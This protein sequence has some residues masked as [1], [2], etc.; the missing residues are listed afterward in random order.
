[1]STL[2][3]NYREYEYTHA[4]PTWDHELVLPTIRLFLSEL[5]PGAK[6]V[7]MGCGNGCLIS[8]FSA[9]GWRLYGIEASIS[10][11]ERA[12]KAYPNVQFMQSDATSPITEGLEAESFDAVISVEVI[13]HVY[14]PR[15]MLTK[16]RSLLKPGGTLVLTT[17]Y[18]GYLKSLGIAIAGKADNHYNPLWDGGHIKFWSHRT[19]AA[20]L[21]ECGFGDLR[22]A[23]K[24]RVPLLWKST[25][26]KATKR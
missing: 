3:T 24:G 4:G 22:F 21:R 10:G 20:A 14:D 25:I 23:P 19:L 8:T 6:V 12:R 11:I 5:P 9:T 17:P 15:R 26:I 18:H 13:E 7:D 2:A 16:I 1:M